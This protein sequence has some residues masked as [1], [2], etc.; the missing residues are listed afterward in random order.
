MTKITIDV[1]Q[2]LETPAPVG[3]EALQ[4]A[5][6]TIKDPDPYL[7]DEP[8]EICFEYEIIKAD[9]FIEAGNIKAS[10][11]I[12]FTF[13][14]AEDQALAEWI[15]DEYMSEVKD[16]TKPQEV[17]ASLYPESFC[18]RLVCDFEGSFV[19]DAMVDYV[20]SYELVCVE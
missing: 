9:A 19:D 1:S 18:T 16:G 7:D 8:C 4:D 12:R 11:T 13:S 10:R 3:D 20:N 6:D 5:I 2:E 15:L 14:T 17:I